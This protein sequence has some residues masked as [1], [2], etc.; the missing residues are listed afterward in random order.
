MIGVAEIYHLWKLE[1]KLEFA[2]TVKI[3]GAPQKF[4]HDHVVQDES[5]SV[6]RRNRK[7]II[8]VPKDG[9]HTLKPKAMVAPELSPDLM[10]D[11]IL[12]DPPEYI[13]APQYIYNGLF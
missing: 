11:S 1:I 13:G 5:G 6:Y 12:M 4:Y 10:P 2:Q 8:S 3:N 7:Q 9:D